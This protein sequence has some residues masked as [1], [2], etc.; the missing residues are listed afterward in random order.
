MASVILE[1]KID[2]EIF[3]TK[4]EN[5][6][7]VELSC[8]DLI[9]LLVEESANGRIGTESRQELINRGKDNIQERITIKKLFK[10]K[11]ADIEDLLRKL[12][13]GKNNKKLTSLLQNK[14]LTV[15]S[16]VDKLQLEWQKHDISLKR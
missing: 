7:L 15:I 8:E 10:C 1:E 12:N 2:M 14:F 5:I 9:S 13:E 6:P 16:L 4:N 3:K 11:I